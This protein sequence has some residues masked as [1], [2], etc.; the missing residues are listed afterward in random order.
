[1][2]VSLRDGCRNMVTVGVVSDIHANRPALEAVLA[3]MPDVDALACVGDIVGILGW[4]A[5]TVETVRDR[6][7]YVVFGNHDARVRP[8]FAYSPSFPSAEDEAELVA[9]QLSDGHV[10][11]LSELPERIE[12]DSFIMGHARPFYFRDPG[13]PVHGFAQGDTGMGPGEFTRIGPHLDGKAAFIG[14]THT[15]HAVDCDKFPGQSGLVVNPGSVGVPWYES[16]DYA[17]VDLEDQS[18][19]LRSVE[20][21]Y[22]EVEDRLEATG[23]PVGKYSNNSRLYN[24]TE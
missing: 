4:N 15:Q 9:E 2:R 23:N 12:T 1:M 16:A 5:W 20:Y 3:D 18:Y 7:D 24:V 14:H 17:V 8:E 6:F 11:W 13:Y 21:D 19:E 22:D 10:E